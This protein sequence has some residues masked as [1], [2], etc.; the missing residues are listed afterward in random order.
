MLDILEAFV[1]ERRYSYL[2]LDGNTTIG[3]RQGLIDAFNTDESIF[4]FLL[5]TRVGGVG[6]NLTGANRV[7]LFDPDVRCPCNMHVRSRPAMTD[8]RSSPLL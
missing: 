2:R 6:V 8:A 3:A 7:M 4:V 1:R 5:T